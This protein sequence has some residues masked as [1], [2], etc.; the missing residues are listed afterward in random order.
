M[1]I[2]ILGYESPN[3]WTP[4]MSKAFNE[5]GY[6]VIQYSVS[7]TRQTLGPLFSEEHLKFKKPVPLSDIIRTVH[8]PID[9]LIVAQ[10]YMY[11]YNDLNIPVFYYHT[12]LTSPLT[13]R[14]P[15]HI[16][17][18][19][20][21]MDHWLRNYFPYEHHRAQHRFFLPPAC[22]PPHY[23]YEVPKEYLV[24]YIGAPTDTFDR[25]RDWVWNS[26]QRDMKVIEAWLKLREDV[27][28][29]YD[30]GDEPAKTEVYNE[31]MS[32]SHYTILTAHNGV[33][34]GRRPF[35][36]MACKTVPII[37]VENDNAQECF[38]GLG[39]KERGG[40]QNCY[41]FRTLEDLESILTG[42]APNPEMAERGYNMML[43]NHTFGHR[44]LSL[45]KIINMTCKRL[46]IKEKG[47]INDKNSPVVFEKKLLV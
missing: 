30:E 43:N 20:P 19:L 11:T 45:I 2:G 14:N 40:Q 3:S 35:E 32:K 27:Y 17:Y 18:K 21:E 13:L 24:S 28:C 1:I 26:M 16:L 31:T 23:I 39:F 15:T 8:R 37:W 36:A 33:Y 42:L 47:E 34:I 5:Q 41:F 22:H 46:L 9:L 38:N 44:V 4:L 12:E 25:I 7:K 29:F 6:T 10:S